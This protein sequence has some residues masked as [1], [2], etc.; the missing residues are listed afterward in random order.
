[1]ARRKFVAELSVKGINQLKADLIDYKDNIL[2][3]KIQLLTERLANKGVEIAKSNIVNYDAVF[4][5]ELLEN[6]VAKQGTSTKNNA[7]F[8]IVADSKHAIFVEFGTGQLG[9]EGGYPYPFPNNVDWKYN[10]GKTII[11]ISDGQYGWYYPAN[12]GNW[13]FTQG[14]P[15][16]PFMYETS[17]E[18]MTLVVKTAKEVFSQ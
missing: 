16:R 8:Y 3:Q 17:L 4:T 13:Y 1:M 12:D 6:I 11:E 15:S 5:K 18:L 10:S 2:R 7:I 9:K 14:M